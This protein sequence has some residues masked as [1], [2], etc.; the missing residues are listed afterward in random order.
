VSRQGEQGEQGQPGEGRS[1]PG[2]GGEQPGEGK[3][4]G[5]GK[6]KGRS[7]DPT[8]WIGDELGQHQTEAQQEGIVSTIAEPTFYEL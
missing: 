6:G 4:K 8:D 1:Q 7:S 3:G 2:E 5:K